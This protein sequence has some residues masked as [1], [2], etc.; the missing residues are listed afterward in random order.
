MFIYNSAGQLEVQ[1]PLLERESLF[2]IPFLTGNA[3][4]PTSFTMNA[5]SLYGGKAAGAWH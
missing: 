1:S 5:E 3:A 4:H 2:L